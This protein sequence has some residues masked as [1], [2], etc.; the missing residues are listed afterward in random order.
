MQTKIISEYE[1][2][3]SK[4]LYECMKWGCWNL[5]GIRWTKW[6]VAYRDGK[7]YNFV[8]KYE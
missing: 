7:S 1:I 5:I 8:I 3:N 6:L 4:M 2:M